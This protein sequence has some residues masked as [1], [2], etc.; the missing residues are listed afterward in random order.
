MKQDP[1]YV[2]NVDSLEL[3]EKQPAA[4]VSLDCLTHLSDLYLN[5]VETTGRRPKV[6][7]VDGFMMFQNDKL[8]HLLDVKILFTAS[9]ETLKR[10]RE[11]RKG[12]NTVAGF[13]VDPPNYFDDFVWPEYFKNHQRFLNSG[14]EVDENDVRSNGGNLNEFGLRQGISLIVNEND[15]SFERVIDAALHAL[16]RGVAAE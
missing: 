8:L 6:I 11:S 9:Y 16:L 2:Y 10:R 3:D 1:E 7:L 13:W 4:D 5:T 12:Y 15:T 14:N